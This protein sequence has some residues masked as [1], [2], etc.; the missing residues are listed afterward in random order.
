MFVGLEINKDWRLPGT[1]MDCGEKGRE[2][3]GKQGKRGGSSQKKK[4]NC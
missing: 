1:P 2:L 4:P 3:P